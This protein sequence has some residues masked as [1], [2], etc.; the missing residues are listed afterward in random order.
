MAPPATIAAT[1]SE[2]QRRFGRRVVTFVSLGF[3]AVLVGAAASVLVVLRAQSHTDWV[4]HTYKVERSIISM[5]R[6]AGGMRADA[7]TAL[8]THQPRAPSYYQFRQ[9]LRDGM[10]DVARLTADNPAQR[11]RVPILRKG[12]G[13]IIAVLDAP[14]DGQLAQRLVA[15]EPMRLQVL[16][17]VSKM[18]ADEQKLLDAR[19]AAQE[20]SARLFWTVLPFV[21]ALLMVV[22]FSSVFAIRRFTGDLA[23]SKDELAE[24]NEGL[25]TAV[26][27]RTRDLQRANEEI[28]R[29]A[30]IVSHDLRSPL[31]NVMGFT[32]ELDTARKAL[33]KMI[34]DAEEKAPEIL[35]QEARIAAREDLPEAIGFIRSSTQRMDR[36]IN[37]ILR[38]SREG[39]RA[40]APDLLDTTAIVQ[41]AIDSMRHRIDEAG[42]DVRI[43]GQLPAINCDRVAFEQIMSNLVENAIKY[44]APGRPG[45][46][47]IRGQAHL[48]R[49]TFDVIDNGRGVSPHDHERIFDLFRRSGVQ[50][51]PGEGIGLAHVRALAH[52]LGGT[53]DV[54]SEL[55]KGATFKVILPVVFAGDKDRAA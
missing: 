10:D 40:L 15:Q 2:Q 30:Y 24:M 9:E 32:A 3:L 49:A 14:V 29:F 43:E 41:N 48:G 12:Y 35:T 39:R 20:A 45:E 5:S 44:A 27:I 34:D 33:E 52:R 22:A 47:R 42:A 6:A 38:L 17:T 53:V 25:E 16:A 18:M 54:E 26:Q 4:T 46:V 37:A 51:Q 13:Q 55:D 19:T 31:V 21:G 11:A 36:L 8:Y 28:Q 1:A 50:D 7:L 23:R